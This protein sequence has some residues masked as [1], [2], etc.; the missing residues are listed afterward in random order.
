MSA[1]KRP[2]SRSPSPGIEIKK[3]HIDIADRS[4]SPV[5]DTGLGMEAEEDDE[6][7]GSDVEDS[8]LGT[9]TCRAYFPEY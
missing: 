6:E 1:T 4:A 5:E 8:F 2:S 3:E 9:Y 7:T